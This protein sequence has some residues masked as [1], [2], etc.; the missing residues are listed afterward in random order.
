MYI[1]SKRSHAQCEAMEDL[2][3]G[4]IQDIKEGCM[5][6]LLANGDANGYRF[7]VAKFINIVTENEDVVGVEVHWYAINTHPFS[8]VYKPEMVFDKKNWWKEKKEGVQ[9]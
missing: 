8:G 2:Y 4:S 6:A 5:I 7:W 9:K 1:S 3:S